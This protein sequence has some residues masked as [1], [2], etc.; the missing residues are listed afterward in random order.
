MCDPIAMAAL[1]ITQ[2]VMQYQQ[3]S[4]VA[5]YSNRVADAQIEASLKASEDTGRALNARQTQEN[6]DI[7]D[8]RMQNL[9]AYMENTGKAQTAGSE[10]GV[11]GRVLEF[12][13]NQRA[14][15]FLRADTNVNRAFDDVATAF[16][17]ERQGITSQLHGRIMQADA[18]R[19]PKPSLT[20]AVITTAVQA[21]T[22]YASFSPEGASFGD[23]MNTFKGYFA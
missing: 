6:N 7:A 17:F 13:M 23:N 18:G 1:A 22:A 3:E 20:R 11:S 14:A 9:V 8:K 5:K 16:S 15:D 10:R 12:D 21:G 4:E 19:K 2:G